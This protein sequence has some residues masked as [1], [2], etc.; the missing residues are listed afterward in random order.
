MISRSKTSSREKALAAFQKLRRYQEATATGYVYCISCGKLMN[1]KGAQGG[2]YVSR[3]I[4]TTE[5]EPDNVWPQCP[6]CNGPLSGNIVAFRANLVK[7]I[8]VARVE[9]IE[10]L[11]NAS[12]GDDEAFTRLSEHDKRAVILK[13]NDMEYER[14]AKTFRGEARRLQKEKI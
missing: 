14:L 4:R 11:A 2:H 5:I 3:R 8:G 6:R 12:Q 7:R 10:N 1:V 9:R 13:R